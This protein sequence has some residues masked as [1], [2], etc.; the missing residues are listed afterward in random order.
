ME[1]I[2]G[3]YKIENLINHKLYIGKSN[4]IE[5]RWVHHKALLNKNRHINKP[6]QNAWNK[7]GEE[8]FDFSVIH[9][10]NDNSVLP[11]LEIYYI[12]K[13]NSFVNNHGYNLTIGGEGCAGRIITEEFRQKVG[14]FHRGKIIPQEIRDLYSIKFSGSGNPFYGRKHS[15]ETKKKIS[16]DRISKNW[17]KGGK[18]IKA[19]KVICDGKLY[20]CAGDC[21]DIYNIKSCTLRS[22][23]RGDRPMPKRFQDIGLK[24]V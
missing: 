15:E 24:F 16:E 4:N 10:C 20:D 14:D 2:S 5:S 11:M 9:V 23:L 3:I 19:K 7:Y 18:N 17:S 6:L 12:S 1:H 8:N 21:A 22:W 13:Y